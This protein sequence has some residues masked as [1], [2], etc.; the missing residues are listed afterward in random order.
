MTWAGDILRE[1]GLVP[2]GRTGWTSGRPALS[3]SP[4][5]ADEMPAAAEGRGESGPA[6]AIP[7]LRLSPPSALTAGCGG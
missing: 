5:L 4:L 7:T 3:E 6:G 1:M 2:R